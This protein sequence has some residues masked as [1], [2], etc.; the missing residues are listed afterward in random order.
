MTCTS[1]IESS[2]LRV[3]TTRREE[4]GSKRSVQK[5]AN[6]VDDIMFKMPQNVL[7]E[8]CLAKT[9]FDTAENEHFK[10]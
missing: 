4:M 6:L 9:A 2:F 5:C 1:Y 8:Y 10:V 7:E 3:F